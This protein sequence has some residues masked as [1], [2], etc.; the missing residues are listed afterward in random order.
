MRVDGGE[1][2]ANARTKIVHPQVN[3]AEIGKNASNVLRATFHALR[4]GRHHRH[5]RTAN[6]IE[7]WQYAM[8]PP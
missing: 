3:R 4:Q 2:L 6:G 8:T 1:V 7:Y 5:R